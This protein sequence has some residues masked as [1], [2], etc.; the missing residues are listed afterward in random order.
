[1]S[2]IREYYQPLYAAINEYKKIH[3]QWEELNSVYEYLDSKD[4]KK[5]G[6]KKKKKKFKNYLSKA[7]KKRRKA[8]KK[9]LMRS[10]MYFGIWFM[11]LLLCVSLV[12]TITPLTVS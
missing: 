11:V 10:L 1:M 8:W 3:K 7:K 9:L 5:K 6:K 4:D 12:A 2:D